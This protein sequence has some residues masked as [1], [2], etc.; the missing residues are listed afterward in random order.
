[1]IEY[2]HGTFSPLHCLLKL[3]HVFQEFRHSEYLFYKCFY[4]GQ[5]H[6]E[7]GNFEN[8]LTSSNATKKTHIVEDYR[9]F[10]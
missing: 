1:M 7:I 4:A 10:D 2:G 6:K 9:V 8:I 5:Q 3:V